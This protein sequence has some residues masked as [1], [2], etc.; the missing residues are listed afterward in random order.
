MCVRETSHLFSHDTCSIFS[1]C[2]ISQLLKG[3]FLA[4]NF[5]KFEFKR[6]RAPESTI[7]FVLQGIHK[8]QFSHWLSAFADLTFR[9][10][11]L[12]LC[13][14]ELKFRIQMKFV[15]LGINLINVRSSQ[16]ERYKLACTRAV[17]I[18]VG[19]NCGG[20]YGAKLIVWLGGSVP[21]WMAAIHGSPGICEAYLTFSINVA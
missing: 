11:R 3:N 13:R 4:I 7:S 19:W 16:V 8:Q 2:T 9:P 15:G 21:F 5:L 10:V 1:Q 6:G 14:N 18:C 17:C 12:P 20:L